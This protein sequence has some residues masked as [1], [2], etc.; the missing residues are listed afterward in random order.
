M[1][2][3][4][5]NDGN[6]LTA[7]PT[8]GAPETT[9]A[10]ASTAASGAASSGAASQQGSLAQMLPSLL[11]FAV[12]ILAM[13]FILIR[14]QKK[15]EK[16]Q[17]MMRDALAIGDAVVTIGGITGIV[18]GLGEDSVVIETGSNRDKV[19]VKRWAIQDIT[20]LNAAAKTVDDAA[21]PEDDK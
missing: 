15:K 10:T 9:A 2:I 11:L 13:Y 3:L 8:A 12:M 19:R 14:P 16:Q 1:R 20:E 7:A 21:K 5:T 18:V 17:K 4:L 6:A